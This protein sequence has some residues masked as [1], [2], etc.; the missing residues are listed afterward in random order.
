[1]RFNPPPIL[2][3]DIG[4]HSIKFVQLQ[5]KRQ[6]IQLIT[7]GILEL[8][9]DHDSSPEHKDEVVVRNLKSLLKARGIKNKK[10]AL[11]L[12]R[13]SA[14]TRSISLPLAAKGSVRRVM[15]YE[16]QQPDILLG[17][18]SISDYHVF[19]SSIELNAVVAATREDIVKKQLH[20]LSRA[21][22]T[23]DVIELSSFALLN[24][25]RFNNDRQEKAFCLVNVGAAETDI[26][27]YTKRDFLFTRSIPV[28]GND[29][30]RALSE[31]F[32]ISLKEAEELKRK[33]GIVSLE[34]SPAEV[35][36]E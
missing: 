1:M 36:P 5:Q 32:K 20:L 19:S 31:E 28:G 30:T 23:P 34:D 17:E 14:L 10:V 3:L 13:G 35:H 6:K 25:Y 26:V 22:L 24:A 33:E 21:V 9:F 2:S 15:Q 11:A 27:I 12:S 8:D 29:F 16:L 7:A 18:K 4:S